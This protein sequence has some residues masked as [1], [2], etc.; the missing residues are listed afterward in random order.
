MILVNIECKRGNPSVEVLRNAT[1]SSHSG[2]V[3][4]ASWIKP[5]IEPQFYLVPKLR[6]TL[7]FKN[8][9]SND[10]K[11]ILSTPINGDSSP[12]VAIQTTAS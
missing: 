10:K 11:L 12:H 2:A 5:R 8:F 1:S 4:Y 3:A 9:V 6:N 7:R